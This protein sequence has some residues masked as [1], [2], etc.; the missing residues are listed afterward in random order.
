MEKLL[1]RV[2]RNWAAQDLA[3]PHRTHPNRDLD[4]PPA[5]LAEGIEILAK[6]LD[7]PLSTSWQPRFSLAG[8]LTGN[9]LPIKLGIDYSET[10]ATVGAAI[11]TKWI[12]FCGKNTDCPGGFQF[13]RAAVC[14]LC[15]ACSKGLGSPGSKT[16]G[17]HS[18]SPARPA[19]VRRL[20]APS[21]RALLAESWS[22]PSATSAWGRLRCML[23]D[24]W[25]RRTAALSTTD[26]QSRRW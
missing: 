22:G 1:A 4:T 13:R 14:V 26:C 15:Y 10:S 20:C 11:T 18:D 12:Y 17:L 2:T 3:A 23:V 24:A 19:G 7:F 16:G 9:G 21:F 25:S 5:P 6:A 8:R